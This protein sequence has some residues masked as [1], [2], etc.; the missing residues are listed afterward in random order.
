M[1]NLQEFFIMLYKEKYPNA[2]DKQ[3]IT[4]Y[5]HFANHINRLAF[6]YVN[7]PY[8]KNDRLSRPPITELG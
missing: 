6:D 1:N 2:T 3:V 7:S 4:E 5:E 8:Y